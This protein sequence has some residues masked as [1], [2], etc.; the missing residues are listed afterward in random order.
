VVF[1]DPKVFL[2]FFACLVDALAVSFAEDLFGSGSLGQV[3]FFRQGIGG[4]ASQV[5]V[6]DEADLTFGVVVVDEAFGFFCFGED[7]GV[8]VSLSGVDEVVE[9]LRTSVDRQL[10]LFG[11]V[12]LVN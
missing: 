5:F 4:R 9:C 1:F 12:C 10:F 6:D 2:F 11:F 3:W 8:C 7:S